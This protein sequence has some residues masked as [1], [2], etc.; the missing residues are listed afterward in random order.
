[1]LH[2]LERRRRLRVLLRRRPDRPRR[3]LHVA[4]HTRR[5]PPPLAWRRRS[6]NRPLLRRGLRGGVKPHLRRRRGRPSARARPHAHPR[7]STRTSARSA[8]ASGGRG[9]RCTRSGSPRQRASRRRRR[10]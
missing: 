2:V 10:G 5:D 1:V 7:A 4:R 8:R 6:P 3:H 9:S